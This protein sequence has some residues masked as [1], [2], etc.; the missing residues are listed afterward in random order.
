MKNSALLASLEAILDNILQTEGGDDIKK[1]EKVKQ[2]LSLAST[3]ALHASPLV[4][5]INMYLAEKRDGTPMA[6]QI[7]PKTVDSTKFRQILRSKVVDKRYR[8]EKRKA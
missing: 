6:A 1:G 8:E 3:S 4:T 2:A 5:P 7:D